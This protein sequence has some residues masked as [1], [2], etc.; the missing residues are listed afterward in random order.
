MRVDTN[1]NVIKFTH[2]LTHPIVYI[3]MALPKYRSMDEVPFTVKRSHKFI[4]GGLL[5]ALV[6]LFEM[7]YDVLVESYNVK[8][9]SFREICRSSNPVLSKKKIL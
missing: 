4:L 3:G 9:K 2:H 5:L 1:Y 6:C 7:R 8:T